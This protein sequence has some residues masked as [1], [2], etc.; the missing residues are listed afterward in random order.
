LVRR[1]TAI[2]AKPLEMPRRDSGESRLI[3]LRNAGERLLKVGNQ[4]SSIVLATASMLVECVP[5]NMADGL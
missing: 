3:G 2:L 4:G 5:Q 1:R